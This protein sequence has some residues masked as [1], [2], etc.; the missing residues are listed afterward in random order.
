MELLGLVDVPLWCIGLVGF[1]NFLVFI[2]I[3]TKRKQSY[4]AYHGIPTKEPVFLVG[5]FPELV[6]KGM[7]YINE[8]TVK[9]YGKVFGSY[10]GNI[11]MLTVCDADF[12]KQITVK[13]FS[14]F[15][16]RPNVLAMDKLW[17]SSITNAHGDHWRFLRATLSPSFSSGK[18]R[19]MEP[20][21]HLCLQTLHELIDQK[22]KSEPDGF[23]LVP[24]IN[25]YTMDVICRLNFGLDISAQTSPDHPFIKNA[26]NIVTGSGLMNPV[27]ILQL[28][29]PDLIQTRLRSLFTSHIVP[30][31]PFQY[32]WDTSK[33]LFEERKHENSAHKDLLQNM[34]NAHKL[35]RTDDAEENLQTFDDFKKRGLTDEEVMINSV[36]FLLG[37]YDTVATALSWLLYDLAINPE[38]QE[39]LVQEIDAHVEKEKPTYDK[40]FKLQ[41]L[42][43]VVNETL[44]VHSPSPAIFRTALEDID[45]NGMHIKKGL[46]IAIRATALHF[47]PEYWDEPRKYNPDRFAPENQAN[48]NQY[49]YLPFGLGPRN[50]IAKRLAMLEI[51]ATVV[52]LL[53]NYI[54][55]KTDQLE[56]PM[57]EELVKSPRPAKPLVLQ[58][59]QR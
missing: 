37:G 30:K 21:L 40:V 35:D 45:I 50:C 27:I 39:K 9:K 54:L 12:V 5:D 38:V 2:Y 24:F 13:E 56:V 52:S 22:N 1:L 28:F 3:Y 6:K 15:T 58:I 46:D 23:D 8:E 49:A 48:I 59:V 31:K 4:F 10:F 42:D 11:P 32:F 53:Q 33:Q 43:M 57:P 19:A 47:M 55:L 25:G 26:R 41:Y 34:I 17:N 44:R 51:K 20:H 14:K 7:G 36:M 18:L 16:D 29:F